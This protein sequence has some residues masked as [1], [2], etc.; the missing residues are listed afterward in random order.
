MKISTTVTLVLIFSVSTILSGPGNFNKGDTWEYAFQKISFTCIASSSIN[1]DTIFG[2]I[3]FSLDS[4]SQKTDTT[5]WYVT[6]TD[7]LR[8]KKIGIFDSE[9]VSNAFYHQ[10]ISIVNSTMLSSD[11]NA[12][13]FSFYHMP[14][15]T[16]TADLANGYLRKTVEKNIVF[17]NV[18]FYGFLKTVYSWSGQKTPSLSTTNSSGD[19]IIWIDSIGLYYKKSYKNNSSQSEYEINIDNN[20]ENYR[21]LRHN[22]TSLT[23]TP[24]AIAP[25]GD[26]LRK[27]AD[28]KDMPPRFFDIRG[29]ALGQRSIHFI[30]HAII[31]QQ[32]PN[33][34]CAIKSYIH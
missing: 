32:F 29:R 5:F 33:G 9:Y 6:K 30:N 14:D 27:N 19:S 25:K 1:Y 17:N 34:R 15:S 31:I 16:D 20:Y 21:L 10:S 12:V 2:K 7:S 4:I 13:F 26:N 18:Q 11:G 24:V 28:A 8:V 22:G 3:T 23:V